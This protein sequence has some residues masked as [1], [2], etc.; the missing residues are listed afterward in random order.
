[1]N[2]KRACAGQS[3]IHTRTACTGPGAREARKDQSVRSNSQYFV[4]YIYLYGANLDLLKFLRTRKI[5]SADLDIKRTVSFWIVPMVFI[6]HVL[7]VQN[8]VGGE[9]STAGQAPSVPAVQ[10]QLAVWNDT[11]RAYIL[12]D[13]WICNV[14]TT[15]LRLSTYA[16]HT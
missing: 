11:R 1:M 14:H 6:H 10:Q 2:A 16:R 15:D 12:P 8:V 9:T 13:V 7:S 3:Y 5:Q 4:V